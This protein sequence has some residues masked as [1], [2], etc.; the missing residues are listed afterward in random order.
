MQ[1]NTLAKGL[2]ATNWVD[3]PGSSAG[4]NSVITIDSTMPT[5]FYRLR[6]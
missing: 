6:Q 2:T 1:T 3:V 5:V 4:T